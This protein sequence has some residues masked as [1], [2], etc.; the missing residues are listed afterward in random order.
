MKV[1]PSK[2]T[3][4]DQINLLPESK[5]KNM[6]GLRPN[7]AASTPRRNTSLKPENTDLKMHK[8]ESNV[9]SR[10]QLPDTNSLEEEDYI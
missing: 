8:N 6:E 10:I 1:Q 3:G 4:S 7:S 2:Q 9:I 5:K